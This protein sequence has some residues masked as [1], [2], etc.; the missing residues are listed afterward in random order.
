MGGRHGCVV[1][2]CWILVVCGVNSSM[3]KWVMRW[4]RRWLN[5]ATGR[6]SKKRFIAMGEQRVGYDV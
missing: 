5:G 2:G 1:V 6:G 3:V 4:V